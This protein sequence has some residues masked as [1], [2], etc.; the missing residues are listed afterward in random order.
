MPDTGRANRRASVRPPRPSLNAL[1][2]YTATEDGGEQFQ[3]RG[4]SQ[5]VGIESPSIVV[6][7]LPGSQSMLIRLHHSWLKLTAA[8]YAAR[9]HPAVNTWCG[10]QGEQFVR[11]WVRCEAPE[12]SAAGVPHQSNW[13]S[14]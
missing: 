12:L 1:Y 14:V 5:S 6:W 7:S 11:G 13:F 8:S 10:Y 2:P 9:A 4:E 3:R